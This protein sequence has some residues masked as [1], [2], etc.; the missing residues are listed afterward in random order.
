MFKVSEKKLI[1][2]TY[3]RYVQSSR[4][5]IFLRTVVI[6]KIKGVETPFS[7]GLQP[8]EEDL[9]MGESYTSRTERQ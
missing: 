2:D 5:T 1:K 8:Y 9:V 3:C 7:Q 4:N 6:G